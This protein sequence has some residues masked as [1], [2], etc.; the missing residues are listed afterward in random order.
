MWA[1]SAALRLSSAM[2][3]FYCKRRAAERSNDRPESAVALTRRAPRYIGPVRAP[4]PTWLAFALALVTSCGGGDNALP[5]VAL[6]P[7][8]AGGMGGAG[9]AGGR[10]PGGDPCA[11]LSARGTTRFFA[12]QPR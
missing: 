8:G 1:S 4:S 5:G 11:G 3:G 12:V 2:A 10:A 7:G 6:V 9:G